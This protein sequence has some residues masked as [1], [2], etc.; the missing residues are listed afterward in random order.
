MQQRFLNIH[1]YQ[2]QKLMKNFGLRV[3]RG[4]VAS[5][6]EEAEKIARELGLLFVYS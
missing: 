3:P 6:P 2:G 5:T 1:E 4:D